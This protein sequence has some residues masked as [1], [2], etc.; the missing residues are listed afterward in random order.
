MASSAS[1]GVGLQPIHVAAGILRD[2]S[3]R[4]L[5]TERLGDSPFAGLWE[6]PGGKIAA[7]ETAESA[8]SRELSEELGVAI[9]ECEHFM[10]VEHRYSDRQVIIEF[11]LVTGW[12]SVPAGLEG[13]AIRWVAPGLLN[14]D[15]LLP[16][17]MPVL[18][19]LQASTASV[20]KCLSET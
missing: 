2:A 14:S 4:V 9:D 15:E 5:V 3:G 1:G 18:K 6:F 17:D 20:R 19:A 10:R 13:Q 16:A 8:L 11:Y 7:G 12:R